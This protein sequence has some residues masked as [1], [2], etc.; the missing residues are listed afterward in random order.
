MDQL[1]TARLAHH[2]VCRAGPELERRTLLRATTKTADILKEMHRALRADPARY[3][4]IKSGQSLSNDPAVSSAAVEGRVVKK[5]LADELRGSFFA[6]VETP[7]G[8]GYHI[9]LDRH[10]AEGIREGDLVTLKALP[11]KSRRKVD[12]ELEEMASRNGGVYDAELLRKV[13]DNANSPIQT[14]LHVDGS[15]ERGYR[16]DG[17]RRSM[18]VAEIAKAQEVRLAEL[19]K[20]GVVHR[21]DGGKWA[22]PATLTQQLDERD[23]AE[24]RHR[25]FIQRQSLA[26]YEQVKHPGP[27]WLDRV[28]LE[29]LAYYGFGA[30]VRKAVRDRQE[31]LR[32]FGID[33][34]DP[35]RHRALSALERKALAL[36]RDRNGGLKGPDRGDR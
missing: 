28:S 17:S 12:L 3:R 19:E 20:L 31:M 16:L 23:K 8:G 4:I 24:P 33:P 22:I 32:T 27:V 11:Q 29:G 5:G 34:N 25:L 26:L 10:A 13:A 14:I 1:N 15:K 18:P 2:V 6:V 9:P 30:D 35:G 7:N 36:S 21:L